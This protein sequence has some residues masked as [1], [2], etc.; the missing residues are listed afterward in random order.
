[1]NN[2][3]VSLIF[4]VLLIFL[5]GLALAQSA[6]WLTNLGVSL[7]MFILGGIAILFLVCY[8]LAGFD[9]WGWLIPTG[10]FAGTAITLFLVNRGVQGAVLGAPV[11][12]GIGLPF[13]APFLMKPRKNWWAL[14]PVWVFTVI[15]ALLF[16]VDRPIRG[17][18]IGSLV[19]WSVALPFLIV[20]LIDRSQW[21]ALIPAFAC[22]AVGAIPLLTLATDHGEFIGAFV[23]FCI[24]LPF[25]VIFARSLDNW[26]ALIPAGANGSIA[27]ML[28]L[29]GLL[30]EEIANSSI[31]PAVMFFGWAVTFGVLWLLRKRYKT[32]WAVILVLIL[33]LVGVILVLA[34]P[35]LEI[36]W[37][38]LLIVVGIV[39]LFNGLRRKGAR[40]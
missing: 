33:G 18:A 32:E 7:W 31:P 22:A 26:W 24:A 36:V 21:W 12:L 11:L 40:I 34:S 4:G 14:I 27:L 25:F 39:I 15:V 30:P 9:Q 23:L 10:I 28:V 37:P 16:L 35:W 6:G 20:Y 13:L 38:F 17:E 19:L 3:A 5:G 29:I 2:R 8:V 1:M